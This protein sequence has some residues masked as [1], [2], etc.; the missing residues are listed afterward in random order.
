[1][2]QEGISTQELILK[3]LERIE[4][5]LSNLEEKTVALGSN[6]HTAFLQIREAMHTLREELGEA[7]GTLIEATWDTICHNR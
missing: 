1:M 4:I 6:C 3:T 5:R 7:S 2:E